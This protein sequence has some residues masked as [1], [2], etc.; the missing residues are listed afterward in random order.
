MVSSFSLQDSVSSSFETYL[1]SS[2]VFFAD[3]TPTSQGKLAREEHRQLEHKTRYEESGEDASTKKKKREKKQKQPHQGEGRDN[4]VRPEVEQHTE[5]KK[6]ET[7]SYFFYVKKMVS[8]HEFE[9]K[10]VLFKY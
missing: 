7:V 8:G 9:L 5:E 6:K 10:L 1:S 3:V 2:F 4:K